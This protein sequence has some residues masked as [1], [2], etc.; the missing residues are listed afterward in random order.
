MFMNFDYEF[1]RFRRWFNCNFSLSFDGKFKGL[2]TLLNL[3]GSRFI[4][5][6]Y[7]KL[8]RCFR[9]CSFSRPLAD[10]LVFH[11]NSHVLKLYSR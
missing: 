9:R 4:E 3:Y 6:L 5:H 11:I 8:R 2:S 7:V 10:I 1:C